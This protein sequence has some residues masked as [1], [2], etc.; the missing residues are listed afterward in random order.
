M[1]PNA[2][3]LSS[4]GTARCRTACWWKGR[5]VIH[6]SGTAAAAGGGGLV[7]VLVVE[8]PLGHPHQ[9]EGRRVGGG[10]GGPSGALLELDALA[11]RCDEPAED[12]A[13]ERRDLVVVGRDLDDDAQQRAVLFVE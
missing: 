10:G 13:P 12:R 8:G 6:T 9:R 3:T 4:R 5:A 11:R 2:S 1:P 7:A